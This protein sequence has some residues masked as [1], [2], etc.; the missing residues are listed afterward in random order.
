MKCIE[1]LEAVDLS[2]QEGRQKKPVMNNEAI[3]IPGGKIIC[4]EFK[5]GKE[6]VPEQLPATVAV[7]EG[8]QGVI[9]ALR[10]EW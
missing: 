10:S 7:R 8:P 3:K 5:P 6:I 4:Q 9:S 1:I 2:R